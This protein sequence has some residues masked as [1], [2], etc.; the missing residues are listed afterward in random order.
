DKGRSAIQRIL[1]GSVARHI[2]HTA[3]CSVLM[4]KKKN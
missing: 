1:I 3:T 4:V 2:L